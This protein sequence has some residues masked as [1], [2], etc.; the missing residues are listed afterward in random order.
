MREINI[1]QTD[2]VSNTFRHNH[3]F[4]NDFLVNSHES[5]NEEATKSSELTET[6]IKKQLASRLAPQ[7][8]QLIGEDVSYRLDKKVPQWPIEYVLIWFNLIGGS[9]FIKNL[10]ENRVDGD[11]LLRITEDELRDDIGIH[12]GIMNKRIMRELNNLKQSADYSSIDSTG[13][14]S[15]LKSINSEYSVYTYPMLNAGVNVDSLRFLTDDQL[16]NVCGISNGIHR[17]CIKDSIQKM[18]GYTENVDKPF[19]VFI[20]YRRST[21]YVL[22]SLLKV[23]L[24]IRDY[25]VFIDMKRSNDA[26]YRHDVLQTV[27]QS[28]NFI[29]ALTQD[30][31]DGDIESLDMISEEVA[32]AKQSQCNIIPVLDDFSW[33][34]PVPDDLKNLN[35]YNSISWAHDYQDACVNKLVKFMIK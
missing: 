13:L 30:S 23:Y 6:E 2:K 28:K 35:M 34:S 14:N 3:C 9:D 7:P 16:K 32:T 19:D 11:L 10:L 26:K 5:D 8:C 33:S 29:I 12:N 20:S 4:E 31:L 17:S 1:D 24:E 15:V 21:S 25:K 22:A 18:S 27:K